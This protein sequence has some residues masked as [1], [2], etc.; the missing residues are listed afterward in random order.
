M[1]IMD[2]QTKKKKEKRKKKNKKRW[3][4]KMLKR[5]QNME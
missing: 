3:V 1:C 5:A 4:Q 2:F